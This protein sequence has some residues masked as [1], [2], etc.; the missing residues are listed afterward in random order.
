M[1]IIYFLGLDSWVHNVVAPDKV[2][3][4]ALITILDAQELN[5]C[6]YSIDSMKFITKTNSYEFLEWVSKSEFWKEGTD[7]I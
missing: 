7:L 5:Y 1:Y 2:T 6:V 3:S 4:I